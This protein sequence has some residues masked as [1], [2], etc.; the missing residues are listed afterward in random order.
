MTLRNGREFLAIP[1]PTNVPDA[2][3]NAMHRPAVE[4]YTGPLVETT[5][6]CL[7]DLKRLFGTRTGRSYIYAANGHGAWEAALTN[8]LSRG[9]KVLVLGSGRFP[10][11]WG[12][13]A[14]FVGVEVEELHFGFRHGVDPAAVET[15]LKADR[16][17]TIKA[18]LMVQVD[19]ASSV[20]NDV[21]AV[22]RAIAA[23]G[24]GALLMVDAIAS[25]ATMPFEMDAWG[26]DVAVTGSQKGLM[27]P[28]GLGFVAAGPRALQA[29]RSAGLRTAYWDWTKRE[30]PLHYE[31]YCGTPPEHLLFGLRQ[32]IDM[33]FEEGLPAVFERH[34]LL[35]EAT[36]RAVAVWSEG[37]ALAFNVVEPAARSNSVTTVR[38]EGFDPQVLRDYCNNTCGVML[39]EGIGELS[40]KGIRIAHMGH[41]NA[42]MMLG[43][44]GV[45]E[46]ALGALGIAHGKGGVQAAVD[47]LAEAVPAPSAAPR[48]DA[49]LRDAMGA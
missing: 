35:A 5:R 23:A 16:A 4:I 2:V 47:F 41:V 49:E 22:G 15:R 19:T 7:E 10:V 34:R 37:D 6:S 20:A 8:V 3:L 43:T 26:I 18:V 11:L 17:G 12:E 44:L 29:H 33:L 32:A 30:G 39:G 38:V 21:A 28:P 1:G 13:M 25:L 48:I 45:I 27:T 42:P 36:R 14:A 9:D 46:M 40:G 31:K 24:H